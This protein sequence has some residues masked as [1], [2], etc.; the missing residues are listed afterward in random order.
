M[1]WSDT[2]KTIDLTEQFKIWVN[3]PNLLSATATHIITDGSRT[4][5][6][7]EIQTLLENNIQISSDPVFIEIQTF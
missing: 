4:D 6:N 7:P 1:A 3:S 2:P 5:K